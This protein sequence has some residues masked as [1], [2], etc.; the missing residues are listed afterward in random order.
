MELHPTLSPP[1]PVAAFNESGRIGYIDMCTNNL[2]GLK[3]NI[4]I[5]LKKG[6]K[7]EAKIVAFDTKTN[8]KIDFIWNK[9]ESGLI[10]NP[11]QC[12]FSKEGKLYVL[13]NS[14][15]ILLEI[16]KNSD[17]KENILPSSLAIEYFIGLVLAS[18]VLY[19]V[20]SIIRKK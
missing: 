14:N 6:I 3:N 18:F 17:K 1:K 2:F 7:E 16:E 13:E 19:V 4:F 5:P 20:V 15:G 11:V 8:S 10:C 12:L 9:E